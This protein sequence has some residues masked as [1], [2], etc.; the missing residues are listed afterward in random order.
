MLS[1]LNNLGN[2]K[3]QEIGKRN[4]IRNLPLKCV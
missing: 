3:L 2:Y 1:D 4:L